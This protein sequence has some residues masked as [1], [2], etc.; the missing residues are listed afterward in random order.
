MFL[1]DNKKDIECVKFLLLL[2]RGRSN[3]EL[4]DNKKDIEWIYDHKFFGGASAEPSAATQSMWMALPCAKTAG[5]HHMNVKRLE[6][7]DMGKIKYIYR[8]EN[9]MYWYFI[10]PRVRTN[11]LQIML[12][13]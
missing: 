13:K 6:R 9:S 7:G 2:C 3:A 10:L 4:G 12:K 1:Y 11:P 5:L 8:N